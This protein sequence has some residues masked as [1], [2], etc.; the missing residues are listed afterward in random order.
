MIWKGTDSF[1][2]VK[3]LKSRCG[4]RSPALFPPRC[5]EIPRRIKRCARSHLLARR[6]VKVLLSLSASILRLFRNRR[7]VASRSERA[8]LR[9]VPLAVE[10]G[11]R[12]L[13][14]LGNSFR[15]GRPR[16]KTPRASHGSC[17]LLASRGRNGRVSVKAL[18]A[19]SY[20]G[21]PHRWIREVVRSVDGD[22]D[23]W[24]AKLAR[25]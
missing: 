14:R 4:P 18:A 9:R 11:A 13:E 6:V 2:S 16:G 12:P 23:L 10:I 7:G 20:R 21:V 5:T 19:Y 17:S 24:S 25:L 8:R 22:A 3:H 15:S 1:F